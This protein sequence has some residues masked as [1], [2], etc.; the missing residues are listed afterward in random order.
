MI[1][2]GKKIVKVPYIYYPI[3][4]WEDWK[5]IRALLDNSSKINTMNF[6]F[7]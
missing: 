1:D 5:Q 3:W 2:G 7:T 6:Y 4:F